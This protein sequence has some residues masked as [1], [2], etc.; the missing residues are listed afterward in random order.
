MGVRTSESGHWFRSH[1]YSAPAISTVALIKRFS[2]AQYPDVVVGAARGAGDLDSDGL[3]QMQRGHDEL[4]DRE[5]QVNDARLRRLSHQIV[6]LPSSRWIAPLIRVLLPRFLRAC[7]RCVLGCPDA[8]DSRAVPL[9]SNEGRIASAASGL[10]YCQHDRHENAQHDNDD[11]P[12]NLAINFG[13]EGLPQFHFLTSAGQPSP[14]AKR[15]PRRVPLIP[16]RGSVVP[17]AVQ[18]EGP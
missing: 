6:Y 8:Q 18:L 11:R 1:R 14:D 16:R 9:P 5:T 13:V 10:P 7:G 2:P 12:K 4:T 15:E 17:L 3:I